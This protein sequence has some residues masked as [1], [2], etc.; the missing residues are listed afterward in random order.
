[1]TLLDDIYVE[2]PK[3]KLEQ[4]MYIDSFDYSKLLRKVREELPSVTDKYL[5]DGIENLK[6]YYAVRLLDP[7][8]RHGV[9][10]PVDVFWHTHIVFTREYFDFCDKV[11]GHYIHH[12]PLDVD[13]PNAL[14]EVRQIYSHTL[15]M[16]EKIFHVVDREWWPSADSPMGP[17]CYMYE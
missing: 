3:D 9:S 6:R 4:L 7:N 5:K 13:D 2:V 8:K 12:V 15:S 14:E 16:H 11:F 1:M 17:I 10:V